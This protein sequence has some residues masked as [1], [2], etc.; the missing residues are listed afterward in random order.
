[1]KAV[2]GI[3]TTN[4]KLTEEKKYRI[5]NRSQTDRTL[6]IEH[7]NRTNQ[8]FKL[9]DTDKPIEDTPDLYRF[10]TSGQGRGD[11]DLHGEGRKGHRFEHHLDQQP[12]DQIRYF[13]NLAEASPALKQKLNEAL[14]LKGTWDATQREL[15]QVVA[16]LNR[17]NAD[18]DRIRKNLRETPKEA[19][20]YQTY[21]KK[22]SDQ[23]KEIDSL[24]AKQKK[25]DERRICLT[26]EVRG[27]SF[28]HLRLSRKA[29]S[30]MSPRT[31]TPLSGERVGVRSARLT[32][33]IN[34]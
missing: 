27:L 28:Q 7:P 9:V 34:P 10:Q 31:P 2:R 19:E 21:L 4:T 18:Q 11:Q 24:T 3:V 5:I 14:A 33:A 8:Q 15:N 12:E 25:L 16:D 29:R 26:Q 13:V 6:L 32:A 30:G 1:M 23:E 20:V 22:L 17:L